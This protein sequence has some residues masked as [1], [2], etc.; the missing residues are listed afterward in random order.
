[1]FVIT[2]STCLVHASEGDAGRCGLPAVEARHH[3][4]SVGIEALVRNPHGDRVGSA[5][6]D[7]AVA[8]GWS[9]DKRLFVF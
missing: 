1:M 5:V 6:G 9:V 7:D 3:I 2:N 4:E 8:G